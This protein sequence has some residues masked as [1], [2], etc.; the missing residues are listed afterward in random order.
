[1]AEGYSP[2]VGLVVGVKDGNIDMVSG[3]SGPVDAQGDNIA[4]WETGYFDPATSDN[5]G[6]PI[7]GYVIP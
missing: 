4:V 6:Y 3:N 5:S 7:L 1:M 2:H